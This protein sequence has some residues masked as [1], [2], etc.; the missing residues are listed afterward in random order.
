M[1]YTEEDFETIYRATITQVSKHVFFRVQNLEDAQDL[2]QDL[3]YALY[4]HMQ[5]C[6]DKIENPQAYL[7]QMANNELTSYYHAK[8]HRPVTLINDELNLIESIPDD[9]ELETQ[10]LNKVTSQALWD[11]IN[12][13]P[14]PDKTLLIAR[15]RYEMSFIDISMKI[16]LPESTIKSK[17]YNALE[18][19]KKKFQK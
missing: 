4:R 12:K 10:V 9:F 17:V 2:V 5:K 1:I 14:E 6:H 8:L 16:N 7:I 19:L 18:A 11:E 15:Y 3:Y 13:L